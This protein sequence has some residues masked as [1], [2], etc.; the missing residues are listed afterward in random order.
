MAGLEAN[1]KAAREHLN[2]GEKIISAVFGAYETKI[3]GNSTVRNGV[4]LATDQRLVFFGKKMFGYDM[5]VFPFANISSFEQG[6][7]A[8]GHKIAFYSSGNKVTM[9]WINKGDVKKFVE[10]MHYII[11]NRNAHMQGQSQPQYQHPPQQQ[12]QQPPQ[13]PSKNAQFAEMAKAEKPKW[14]DRKFWVFFWLIIFFP[15]GVYALWKNR[16]FSR[17]AKL[18][19]SAVV[20][21]IVFMVGSADDETGSTVTPPKT[22][23]VNN[24]G[25]TTNAVKPAKFVPS[26]ALKQQV[27]AF[28]QNL[29]GLEKPA[30]T[31]IESFSNAANNLGTKYS[32]YDLYS[33][34]DGAEKACYSVWREYSDLDNQIPSGLPKNIV[35]MLEESVENMQTAYFTKREAFKYAKKFLDDQK[36]SNM[37]K[38]KDEMQASQAF[39]I[40]AVAKLTEAKMELGMLDTK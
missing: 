11:G 8:M 36:P 38:Y 26:E 20:A 12:Y 1:V 40:G 14:F 18:I 39:V 21:V 16:R 30:L 24:S 22:S 35:K 31:R 25:Q 9:K 32:I 3:M 13:Q 34:A 27:K 23:A 29:T 2:Q 37:Q 5:E 28:E 7:G 15:V 17:N 33:Y 6:K 4:F 10:Y 19:I